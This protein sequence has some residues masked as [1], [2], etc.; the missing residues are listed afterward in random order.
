MMVQLVIKEI[1]VRDYYFP[2]SELEDLFEFYSK[3]KDS[4]RRNNVSKESFVEMV[5]NLELLTPLRV[6]GKVH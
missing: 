1:V 6:E 4:Y 3:S 2:E 5:E